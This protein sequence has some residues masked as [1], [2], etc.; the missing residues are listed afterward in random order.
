MVEVQKCQLS[1]RIINSNDTLYE[2]L[3]SMKILSADEEGTEIWK[4]RYGADNL[5]RHDDMYYFC[6]KV[7]EAEFEDI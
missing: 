6:R 1:N 3:G 5:L 7:I 2:I 4:E